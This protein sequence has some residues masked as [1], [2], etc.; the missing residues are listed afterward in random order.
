MA[1]HVQ[2]ANGG[3]SVLALQVSPDGARL[4]ASIWRWEDSW[5]GP[6]V[7]PGVGRLVA[8]D[9]RD[10][11][12]LAQATMPTHS[13]VTDITLAAGPGGSAGAVYAS[14]ATPGPSLDDDDAWYGYPAHFQLAALDPGRLATWA[15]WTLP[16]RP[17]G[18]AVTPDGARAYVLSGGRSGGP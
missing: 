10:G 7:S 8:V 13:A 11:H 17:G 6:G 12:L 14:I 3:E 4:F 9:T 15:V 18:T 1:R 16:H 5:T 2:L